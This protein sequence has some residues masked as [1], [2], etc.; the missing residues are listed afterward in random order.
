MW[1][2][3]RRSRRALTTIANANS[4]QD[5]PTVDVLEDRITHCHGRTTA[6]L[7]LQDSARRRRA[8]GL[9]LLTAT[10][11]QL[12]FFETLMGNGLS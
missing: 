11:A 10:V 5:R 3:G 6:S 1:S 7:Y 2:N 9:Y 12:P 8:G 4:S